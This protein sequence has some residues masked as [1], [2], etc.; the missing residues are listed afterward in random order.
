MFCKATKEEITSLNNILGT[1][2]NIF[3]QL[4]NFL[5]SEVFFSSNTKQDKRYF[6]MLSL[7]V[8]KLIRTEKY[9]GLPPL[10]VEKRK[11]FLAS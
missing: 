4:I 5:K 11:Q 2:R 3:G 1:Y 8:S 6:I 7:G 10:L 9:L